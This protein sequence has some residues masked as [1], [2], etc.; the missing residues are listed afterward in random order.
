MGFNEIAAK[1][2]RKIGKMS[3]KKLVK[4]NTLYPPATLVAVNKQGLEIQTSDG[5]LL[6]EKVK[7]EG[8]GIMFAKDWINGAKMQLFDKFNCT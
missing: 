3:S 6:V 8:K 1:A 4:E 5:I 2:V 7:P